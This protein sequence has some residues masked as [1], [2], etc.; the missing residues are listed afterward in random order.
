M[1]A[2]DKR[3]NAQILLHGSVRAARSAWA[4]MHVFL[5]A[6][7]S[8]HSQQLRRPMKAVTLKPAHASPEHASPQTLHGPVFTVVVR[9][10]HGRLPTSRAIQCGM[11]HWSGTWQFLNWKRIGHAVRACDIEPVVKRL[12][13]ELEHAFGKRMRPS[14]RRVVFPGVLVPCAA[15]I[16]VKQAACTRRRELRLVACAQ[17]ITGHTT[18]RRSSRCMQEPD[19]ERGVRT[20]FY[21]R[22]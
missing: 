11:R 1:N 5:L 9:S 2:A 6:H 3:L 12:S 10:Q 4:H 15:F 13:I 8:P 14:S 7:S 18:R 22:G 21:P 16:D 19:E 20:G 17:R